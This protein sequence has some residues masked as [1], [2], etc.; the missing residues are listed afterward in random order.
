MYKKIQ[1]ELREHNNCI[2]FHSINVLLFIHDFHISGHSNC[3]QVSLVNVSCYLLNKK[4][5]L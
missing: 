5:K 3:F 1:N 2:I 4:K